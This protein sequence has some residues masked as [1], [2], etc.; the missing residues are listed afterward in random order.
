MSSHHGATRLV[1]LI[2]VSRDG[3]QFGP[4][5][6]EDVQAY[7]ADGSLLSTDLGWVE[8]TAAWVPLPQL[9]SG[10]AAPPPLGGRDAAGSAPPAAHSI[11]PGALPIAQP[12]ATYRC[13]AACFRRAP[14]AARTSRRIGCLAAHPGAPPLLPHA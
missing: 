10:G 13:A 6:P 8:G 9:V 1:M 5:T 7:L 14:R 3:Q 4:Y 2:H 11:S 12:I